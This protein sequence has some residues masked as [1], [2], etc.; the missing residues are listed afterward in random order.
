MEE[1]YNLPFIVRNKYY[2]DEEERMVNCYMS[3][4]RLSSMLKK[5]K[6]DD[7]FEKMIRSVGWMKVLWIVLSNVYKEL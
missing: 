2:W 1:E 4:T 5:S 7:V 3:K 6:E